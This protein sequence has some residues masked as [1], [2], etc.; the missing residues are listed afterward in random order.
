MDKTERELRDMLADRKLVR[1]P[2]EP[3]WVAI[4]TAANAKGYTGGVSAAVHRVAPD[5][6]DADWVG[7]MG[8]DQRE[9]MWSEIRLRR[10]VAPFRRTRSPLPAAT[11]AAAADP[12]AATTL[13]AQVAGLVARHWEVISDG[14]S[15][16]QLRAPRKLKLIQL[17]GIVLGLASFALGTL[18][19]MAYGFGLIL[20]GLALLDYYVFTKRE[21]KFLAQPGG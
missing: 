14:P 4:W 18:T 19:P 10:S 21:T 15:G 6:L 13:Q 3:Q 8:S 7:M 1:W 9:M 12:D 5:L 11:E 16:V 2:T 17:L 20:V